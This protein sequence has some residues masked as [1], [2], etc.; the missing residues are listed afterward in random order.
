MFFFFPTGAEGPSVGS[1]RGVR[2]GVGRRHR[3]PGQQEPAVRLQPAAPVH[4]H[5][6][7]GRT[8]SRPRRLILLFCF[9]FKFV[10]SPSTRQTPPVSPHTEGQA[11]AHRLP[12]FNSV[13]RAGSLMSRSFIP[14]VLFDHLFIG[15][16]HP[17]TSVYITAQESAIDS[18]TPSLPFCFSVGSFLFIC[19]PSLCPFISR[20]PSL[21]AAA[22]PQ[23]NGRYW[24]RNELIRMHFKRGR[25]LWSSQ[26]SILR[27]IPSAHLNLWDLPFLVEQENNLFKL[28]A[29]KK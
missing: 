7:K 16:L 8:H 5:R 17:N 4:H 11:P 18:F 9:H 24:F 6:E 12:L 19:P 27:P 29:K 21:S 26:V 13:H 25:S 3:R 2:P 28:A 20:A 23:W 1:S 14:S 15:L 22:T 10:S